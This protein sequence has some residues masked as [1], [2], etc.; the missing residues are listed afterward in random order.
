MRHLNS[1][2]P[3]QYPSPWKN[4]LKCESRKHITKMTRRGA[5]NRTAGS[6]SSNIFHS[7]NRSF[8]SR[9]CFRPE[10][11]HSCLLPDW[12]R[13]ADQFLTKLSSMYLLLNRD[14]GSA[15]TKER[16]TDD[17]ERKLRWDQKHEK[18][19]VQEMSSL[20]TINS[21]TPLSRTQMCKRWVKITQPWRR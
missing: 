4:R 19:N 2:V 12:I 9:R 21:S 16:K 1:F 8:K 10:H 11:K 14:P 20:I 3:H 15:S 5:T 7:C 18:Q 6:Q 17:E 13:T